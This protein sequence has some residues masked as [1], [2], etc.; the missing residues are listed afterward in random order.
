MRM[1]LIHCSAYRHIDAYLEQEYHP[2]L[3]SNLYDSHQAALIFGTLHSPN[4]TR[5]LLTEIVQTVVLDPMSRA[6][7]GHHFGVLEVD[8]AAVVDGV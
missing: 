6:L 3:T 4:K 2:P 5:H 7:I 1:L 8:D